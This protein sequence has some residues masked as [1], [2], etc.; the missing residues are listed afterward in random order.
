MAEF[1]AHPL[2]VTCAGVTLAV[3]LALA[4]RAFLIGRRMDDTLGDLRDHVIPHFKPP[5][6]QEIREGHR[7]YGD[8]LPERVAVL[9]RDTATQTRKLGE[10]LDAEQAETGR[11]Y[12]RLDGI[13]HHLKESSP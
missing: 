9:E 8:T 11:I 10:H 12:D 13:E 1:L 7:V 5:T 4:G 3:L 6:A 2:V